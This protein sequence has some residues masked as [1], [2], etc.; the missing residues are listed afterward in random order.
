MATTLPS[1]PHLVKLVKLPVDVAGEVFQA[2][3]DRHGR[4]DFTWSQLACEVERSNEIHAAR[5]SRNNAFLLRGS[6]HHGP[7]F[8]LVDDAHFVVRVLREVRRPESRR[9]AFHAMR[10]ALAGGEKGR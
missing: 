2:A 6:S 4:D 1:S 10:P 9:D 8:V 3:V 5:R 7:S